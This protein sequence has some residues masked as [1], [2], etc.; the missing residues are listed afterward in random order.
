MREEYGKT[1]PGSAV[2][3]RGMEAADGVVLVFGV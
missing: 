1:M 2:L 3:F